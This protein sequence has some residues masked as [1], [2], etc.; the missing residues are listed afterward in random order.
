MYKY[1]KENLCQWLWTT[2]GLLPH[3]EPSSV[4]PLDLI[5]VSVAPGAHQELQEHK[6][7]HIS[8]PDS[9]THAQVHGDPKSCKIGKQALQLLFPHTNHHNLGIYNE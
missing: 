8:R 4:L 3:T 5:S 6:L 7:L 2:A 1:E 9:F